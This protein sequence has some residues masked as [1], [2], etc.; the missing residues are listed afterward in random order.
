VLTAIG[1]SIKYVPA[2]SKQKIPIPRFDQKNHIV[3]PEK[4]AFQ[5]GDS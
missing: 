2:L 3:L 5:G 4:Y 1:F